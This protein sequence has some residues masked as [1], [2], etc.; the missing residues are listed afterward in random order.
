MYRRHGQKGSG[1]SVARPDRLKYGKISLLSAGRETKRIHLLVYG[2]HEQTTVGRRLPRRD[3]VERHKRACQSHDGVH[4]SMVERTPG[5]GF[6]GASP[7]VLLYWTSARCERS[8]CGCCCCACSDNIRHVLFKAR[9][10]RK[11]CAATE[12]SPWNPLS[13]R[14]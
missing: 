8:A 9:H 14:P 6:G 5:Y 13:S 7:C 12:K 2:V 3:F 11:N 4:P 10:T 1:V